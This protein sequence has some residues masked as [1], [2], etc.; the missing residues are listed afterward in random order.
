MQRAILQGC[1]V[2]EFRY[3]DS[4]FGQEMYADIRLRL[5]EKKM[6]TK[7][8]VRRLHLTRLRGPGIQFLDC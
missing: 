3:Q 2:S 5:G 4:E 6:K 1:G 8:S 7:V